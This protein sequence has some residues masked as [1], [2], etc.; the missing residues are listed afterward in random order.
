MNETK[1]YTLYEPV[2][3]YRA[4]KAKR[5]KLDTSDKMA[6][7]FREL[8]AQLNPDPTKEAVI[9]VTLSA[10]HM[11]VGHRLMS[12]GTSNQALIGVA[13]TLR[14]ALLMGGTSFIV[15]HNHPSGDPAPSSADARCTLALRA[16]ADAINLS[17]TDHIVLGE[18]DMD[19]RGIGHYSFREAGRL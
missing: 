14:A 13:D 12:L 17:L 15:A 5:L 1:T 16:G 8:F 11:E 4:R 10:R 3:T 9:I 6:A 7:R 19:P 2:I 18:A